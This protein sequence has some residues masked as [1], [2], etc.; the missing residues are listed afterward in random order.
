MMTGIAQEEQNA[1]DDTTKIKLGNMTI[2]IDEGGDGDDFEDFDVDIIEDDDCDGDC[3]DFGMTS[4]F[5]IG[6]NGWLTS[7]NKTA[8]PSDYENMAIDYGASRIFNVNFMFYGADVFNRRLYVSPG[9]GFTW[10][11]YKFNNNIQISTGGDTT[12]FMT[13]SV[14]KFEKFKLR[15]SYLEVPLVVGLRLGDADNNPLTIEAGLIGGLNLNNVVK[16]KYITDG[17]RYKDRIRDDYNINP[18]RLDATARVQIGGFGIFAR[19]GLQSLFQDGKTQE[20]YPFSVGISLGSVS[21]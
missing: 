12:M 8:M 5:N 16:Q 6:A 3:R 1:N 21:S 9:F 17:T 20:V 13:D 11:S 15:T 7:D 2:I 19:Y 4:N 18:F 10:N 14:R